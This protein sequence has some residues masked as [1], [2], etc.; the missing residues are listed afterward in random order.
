[1]KDRDEVNVTDNQFG[2]LSQVSFDAV[3]QD[4]QTCLR[5]IEFTAPYKIIDPFPRD[6]QGI[7]V[8]LL[9]A[10]AGI[11]AGDRQEF[12][13]SI[14]ENAVVEFISQAYEKIH[15]MAKGKATRISKITVDAGGTF[16]FNPQPTIPFGE[17]S[18]EN[19]IEVQL[20][21]EQSRFY[22]SEILTAGRVARGEKFQYHK[23]YNH[24][25]I[26]RNQQLIYRDNA[27]FEP[28]MMDMAGFGMYENYTHM[29]N[30]FI[31]KPLE[32]TSGFVEKLEQVI[33]DIQEHVDVEIG[34]TQLASGDY[35]VR[36][37]ANRAQLLEQV[38]NKIFSDVVKL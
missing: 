20:E 12:T 5:N 18:F 9:S 23:Y 26:W 7:Q 29:G 13:F 2:R 10:S 32:D 15:Q 16:I 31:S 25:L 14:H 24:V 11:M 37:F 33:A 28:T 3:Y 1:M 35:V 38:A 30:I 34:Y 8:M 36:D 4:K 27:R 6:T 19:T 21:N 17:S 22:M